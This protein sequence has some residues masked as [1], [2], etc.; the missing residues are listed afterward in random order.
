M[1][2]ATLTLT[3]DEALDTGNTPDISNFAVTVGGSDRGVDAVAMAGSA[4]TIT[5]ATAVSAGEAVTVD[6]MA[7]T[8]QSD[9]RL[10]DL[11]GNTAASF[12]GQAVTNNTA[13]APVP[14]SPTNLQVA[15]HQSGQLLASWNAPGSGPDPT[16]YTVQWKES[17]GDWADQDDVTGAGVTGTS[18]IITGL[19]DGTE[20]TARVIAT[21]DG[22]ES[23][24]S[25]EV[26]A[27]PTET[28]PPEL[29]S[30]GVDTAT[31]TLTFDEQLDTGETPDKSAFAVTVAGGSWGV[32]AV[33]V[34]GS[35]VT[36]TLVTA[37]VAGDAV[38][39][40][41]TAPAGESDARLKDLAGN[42]ADSFSG[43]IVTND[44]PAAAQLTASTHDVPA[45]HDGSTT[46]TFELRFSE[47]PADGFSYKTLR[48]HAFTVTG[49]EVVKARRLE[50]GKNVRW[51]ISVTPDGDGP[52]TIVLPVTTDCDASGA[53]CTEDGRKLSSR[54]DLTV[55]GPE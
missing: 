40:G 48:D 47:E 4:V 42:A 9:A 21:R 27:T 12:N 31:L 3:F 25:G 32:D 29:S 22:A 1:D 14:G 20:Y 44:T 35:A 34:S 30:A 11:A 43:Q 50:K 10:Q 13:P 38:T 6:Y 28:T 8:G 15:R 23:E 54:L 5:L 37:V 52:V 24:P 41:Y 36:I 39:V 26:T 45:A 49:G 46:F 51:E 53:V 2:G 17:G 55:S 19:T 33:T 16:G 18:H 7:P